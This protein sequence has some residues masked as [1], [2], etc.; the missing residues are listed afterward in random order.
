MSLEK[1]YEKVIS[2]QINPQVRLGEIGQVSFIADYPGI[3]HI[4][5]R[6][7]EVFLHHV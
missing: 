1:A 5:S 3:A 6:L 7:G 2:L 4:M